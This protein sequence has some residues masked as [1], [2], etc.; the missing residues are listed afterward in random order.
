VGR[1]LEPHLAEVL[2]F[3]PYDSSPDLHDSP[4]L[5]STDEVRVPEPAP[6]VTYGLTTVAT[7]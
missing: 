7:L 6:Q 3:E 1:A 2:R 4:D 5:H